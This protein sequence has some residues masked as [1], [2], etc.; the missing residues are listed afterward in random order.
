MARQV[1]INIDDQA[2]KV[3]YATRTGRKLKIVDTLIVP[4]DK[5]DDFLKDE[6]EKDF[7]VSADF[8]K[9]FFDTV[10]IPP[11]KK[12]LWKSL[13]NAELKKRHADG[14]PYTS[15][16]FRTGQKVVEGHRMDEFFV[17]Y[18]PSSE[19]DD[20]ITRFL[21]HGKRVEAIYP[22][23]MAV[24]KVLPKKE[25]PYLCLFESGS[26]KSFFLMMDGQVLFTRVVQS[27]GAGL[28]DYDIQNIN[29]TVNHC[30]QTLR[31]EPV[32]VLYF[33]N[34][35]AEGT[36]SAKSSL[37]MEFFQP[38]DTLAVDRASFQNFLITVCALGQIGRAHV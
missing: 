17:Y 35:P 9:A 23:M 13:I 10:Y 1:S 14:G 18:V 24:L 15:V 12:N 2:V 22:N 3:V 26:T 30:R 29:M 16:F 25:E 36:V 28:S 21:T 6:K 37:S 31:I 32:H 4:P 38:P 20:L 27:L 19:V 34:E 8:R 5:L 7:T 11:V 33:G